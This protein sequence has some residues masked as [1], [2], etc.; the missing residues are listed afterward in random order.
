MLSQAGDIAYPTKRRACFTG[1]QK[2]GAGE[3]AGQEQGADQRDDPPSVV[4]YSATARA[5][6]RGIGSV[7]A[8]TLRYGVLARPRAPLQWLVRRRRMRAVGELRAA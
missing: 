2:V 6:P 7:M 3:R 1:A 5:Q 4:R 8:T